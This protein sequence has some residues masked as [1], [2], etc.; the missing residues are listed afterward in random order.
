VV[1]G[2]YAHSGLNYASLGGN[3]N[4]NDALTQTIT[5]PAG[6]PSAPLTFWVNITTQETNGKSYDY[7]YIEI[8]NAS[9]TLLATPL[10]LSNT[11]A[12]SD[13]NT[14]GVYFQPQS[15][16]LSSYAGK[17]IEVVFHAT[18]DYEKTTTFLIDDVSVTAS[19]AARPRL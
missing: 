17:T 9:G 8:H 13:K 4:E 14:L 2:P 6:A 5:V 11:N 12:T 10:T 19:A 7:L 15:V 1:K 3:N 18:T 16:D